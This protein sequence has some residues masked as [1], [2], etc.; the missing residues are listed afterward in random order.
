[1]FPWA[2]TAPQVRIADMSDLS[3]RTLKDYR[4]LRRLGRG[5]MAEVFLAEQSSL[6]RQIALK[7]LN[8]GLANDPNYVKIRII[9]IL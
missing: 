4:V 6:G 1:M 8:V 5:A 7:V 9:L 2:W 3:G